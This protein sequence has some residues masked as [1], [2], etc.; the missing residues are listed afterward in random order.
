MTCVGAIV[1]TPDD[2]DRPGVFA[3]VDIDDANT[4]GEVVCTIVDVPKGTGVSTLFV[5]AG[6]LSRGVEV[7]G[8]VKVAAVDICEV[9]VCACVLG[10]GKVSLVVCNMDTD[11]DVVGSLTSAL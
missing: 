4:V 5:E 1:D 11:A 6:E 10:D 7:T 3:C 9:L 2:T 8:K